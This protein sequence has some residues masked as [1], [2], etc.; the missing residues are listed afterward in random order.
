MSQH[1]SDLS[2]DG[3]GL[4][5]DYR[6]LQQQ[7]AQ[8]WEHVRDLELELA[9]Q[10][11][12]EE[13]LLDAADET[14]REHKR[15]IRELKR[16]LA[17]AHS[18]RSRAWDQA[19]GGD[20]VGYYEEEADE[21]PPPPPPASNPGEGDVS[22]WALASAPASNTMQ[23]ARQRAAEA[24]A[25]QK[26]EDALKFESALC[27][28]LMNA[29]ETQHRREMYQQQVKYKQM[30]EKQAT[31]ARAEK[32]ELLTDINELMGNSPI[33][34]HNGDWSRVRGGHLNP[35]AFG[36]FRSEHDK[37]R[38]SKHGPR[39][40]R[41]SGNRNL[42]KEFRQAISLFESWGTKLRV[43]RRVTNGSLRDRAVDNTSR[44][45]FREHF[46]NCHPLMKKILKPGNPL[47]RDLQSLL[48]HKVTFITIS[49]GCLKE[50]KTQSTK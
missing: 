44:W 24:A 11:R 16:R 38:Q 18:E 19:G 48:D 4:D 2:D 6:I 22:G 33:G 28:T 31:Q 36:H 23:L 10:R 25:E 20:A 15:E 35:A 40:E 29:S 42:E 8:A 14:E 17:E 50:N 26:W 39:A 45:Y 37:N 41:Y 47:W 46:K 43:L 32:V 34:I 21:S 1:F 3:T 30:L 5:S 49:L 7:K 13:D 12:R 27:R 9:K